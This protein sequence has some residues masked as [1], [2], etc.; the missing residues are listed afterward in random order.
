MELVALAQPEYNIREILPEQLIELYQSSY[1]VN[2]A[3]RLCFS[4]K[5]GREDALIEVIK[6]MAKFEDDLLKSVMEE[7]ASRPQMAIFKKL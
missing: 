6:L 7:Y 1:I 2:N 3:F 4:K 5:M